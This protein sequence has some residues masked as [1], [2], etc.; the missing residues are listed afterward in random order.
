MCLGAHTELYWD[1]ER[2]GGE[3]RGLSLEQL[4]NWSLV[5]TVTLLV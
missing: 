5:S 2:E 3:G 4:R 1:S